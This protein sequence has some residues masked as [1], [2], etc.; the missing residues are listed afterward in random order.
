MYNC[1]FSYRFNKP[2]KTLPTV[3]D[4]GHVTVNKAI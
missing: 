4:N 3:I 1:N 2:K